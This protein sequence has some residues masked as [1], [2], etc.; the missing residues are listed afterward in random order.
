MGRCCRAGSS[1]GCC[2]HS[3]CWLPCHQ[4]CA[5]RSVDHSQK[6]PEIT[7]LPSV[8]NTTSC[9]YVKHECRLVVE[10]EYRIVVYW[11]LGVGDSHWRIGAKALACPRLLMSAHRRPTG[12]YSFSG[13]YTEAI[14]IKSKQQKPAAPPTGEGMAADLLSFDTSMCHGA[15]STRLGC[16]IIILRQIIIP[17]NT[18][19]HTTPDIHQ[20]AC[21]RLKVTASL[22][23][24]MII[25][26]A[27][28]DA[29]AEAWSILSRSFKGMQ[30]WAP[31][32]LELPGL[33]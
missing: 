12:F 30:V 32:A 22:G 33:G 1:T 3:C 15:A 18:T 16:Q 7:Q 5:S 17:R 26:D 29:H 31:Y 14:S 9:Q 6:S 8:A 4:Q 10:D 13:R 2:G 21:W 11:G 27:L 23:W 25:D 28:G 20:F 24:S 19:A